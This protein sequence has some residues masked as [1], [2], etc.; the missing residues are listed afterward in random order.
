MNK[1]II[2]GHLGSDPEMKYTPGGKAVTNFNVAV[3]DGWGDNKITLWYRVTAW[4][5]KAEFCANYLKKGSKVLVEGSLKPDKETGGPRV[6]ES[7]GKHGASFELTAFNVEPQ[8]KKEQQG[9]VQES[10]DDDI[11]F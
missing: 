1:T 9:S 2:T 6:W 8:D 3:N 5:A 11:N 10:F 4:E 7:N